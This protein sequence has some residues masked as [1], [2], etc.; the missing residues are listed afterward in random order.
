MKH[1]IR[2]IG[3]REPDKA[4]LAF[5]SVYVGCGAW[6]RVEFIEPDAD[7][8]E[9]VLSELDELI[10]AAAEIAAEEDR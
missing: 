4:E 6:K 1:S 2:G 8:P 3:A 10:E 5:G 9:M 7:D